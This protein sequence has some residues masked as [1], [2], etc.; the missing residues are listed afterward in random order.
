MINA[1][2][3]LHSPTVGAVHLGI[4][5]ADVILYGQICPKLG[6]TSL[7]KFGAVHLGTDCAGVTLQEQIDQIVEDKILEALCGP[8]ASGDTVRVRFF[9]PCQVKSVH[10]K[11]YA[12][13]YGR[14]TQ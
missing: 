1:A 2:W 5:C 13:T 4:E 3:C 9:V 6:R 7:A 10:V 8:D 11:N 12:T 14:I